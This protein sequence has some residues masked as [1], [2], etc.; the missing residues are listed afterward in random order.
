MATLLASHRTKKSMYLR[1]MVTCRKCAS[2]I[3]VYRLNALPEE[4]SVRCAKC[5]TRGIHNKREISMQEMPERRSK[6]RKD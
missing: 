6:P 1:G 2:P 5:G 3:Y 4:I